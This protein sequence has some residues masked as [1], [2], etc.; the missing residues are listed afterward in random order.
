M[1]DPFDDNQLSVANDGSFKLNFY[2]S[3]FSISQ[4]VMLKLDQYE[5][6]YC[7]VHVIM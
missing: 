2:V 6:E 4:A 5:Y 3:V 1:C 7:F